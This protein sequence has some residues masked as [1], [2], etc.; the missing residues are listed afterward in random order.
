MHIGSKTL[1]HIVAGPLTIAPLN[2]VLD[3]IQAALG[4]RCDAHIEWERD[5]NV[6]RLDVRHRAPVT[7]T[8]RYTPN[9][10]ERIASGQLS[11]APDLASILKH[12]ESAP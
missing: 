8:M 5:S 1:D 10:I 7:T 12:I 11:I 9:D 4:S 6:Y 3:H 2:A